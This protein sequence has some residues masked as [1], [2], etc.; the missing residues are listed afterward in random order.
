[1]RNDSFFVTGGALLADAGSY[2]QRA[3]DTELLAALR[4]GEFCYVLTTRQMGKT[5]LTVRAAAQLRDEGCAV[6]VLDLTAFGQNLD[7][8]QWYFSMLSDL[9]EKLKLED[10]MEAYWEANSQRAPLHRFFGAIR[11]VYLERK[12]KPLVIFV[13][14]IDA[15]RSLRQFKADEFFAGIRECYN[16][17]AEDPKFQKLTFCLLGV[18]TPSDLIS[19]QR[20]TPFNIGHG[21]ELADFSFEEATILAGGLSPHHETARA[22]LERVLEWTS[23][24]PYLTQR[25]C[26][27]LTKTGRHLP[28]Q[29]D[30]VCQQLFLGNEAR[31]GDENLQFVRDRLLRSE[32]D[33]AALLDTYARVRR[34]ELVAD[35][36]HSPIINELRLCGIVRV[37]DGRLQTRN[38]IY[39]KAFD[40]K[41]VRDHLPDAE[42]KRQR[43][44][45]FRGVRRVAGAA[46]GVSLLVGALAWQASRNARKAN[47]ASAKAQ[48][49]AEQITKAAAV[50]KNAAEIERKAAEIERQAALREKDA[51]AKELAAATREKETTERLRKANEDRLN[52]A[53]QT[54]AALRRLVDTQGKIQALLEAFTPLLGQKTGKLISESAENLVA[55]ISLETTNDPRIQFG[56]AGLRRVC[57]RLYLKLGNEDKALHQ[58]EEARRIVQAELIRQP[59]EGPEAWKPDPDATKRLLHDCHLLVGDIMLG[60]RVPGVAERKTE[61]EYEKAV[62]ALRE[63]WQ[64]AKVERAA[65]PEDAKWRATYFAD[66]ANLGDTARLFHRDDEARQHY[67]DAI[68]ELQA[69]RKVEP[70]PPDLDWLRASFHDR[71]GT[72]YMAQDDLE[73]AKS[74]FNQ[75]LNLREAGSG[76]GATEDLEQLSD[77]AQS[78]NKLG[79]LAFAAADYK[80]ALTYYERSLAMRQKLCEQNARLDWQRNLGFTLSNVAKSLW[81]TNQNLKALQRAGERWKLAEDLLNQ[82]PLDANLRYDYGNALFGYADILLNV[83]D[84]NLQD[85]QK[86]LELAR[87]AVGRTERRDPRCLA[88]LAQALRLNKSGAEA[89]AVAEE[90][91]KLLPPEDKRTQEDKEVAKE[92]EF[93]LRT[94]RN[95][96]G[97]SSPAAPAKSRK[98]KRS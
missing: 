76:E 78:Y 92:V 52:Q 21:I 53:E 46:V 22:L 12:R 40:L 11:E 27:E 17:R 77:I 34:G 42:A 47:E 55:G 69:M 50:E 74:E 16:R 71:L 9:A 57:G 4:A 29:V 10:E 8:E 33:Q 84:K 20:M 18:A 14:E 32:L 41:W 81:R 59:G 67:T 31:T 65:H 3:A 80:A 43:A 60:G 61:E 51:A 87:S 90:A 89:Y 98:S 1:M 64:L 70:A 66:W 23:G 97:S 85:W 7:V 68:K 35:D 93:E 88:L 24:H 37:A 95:S 6:V 91:S 39:S 36:H 96:R 19:D 26:A 94:S 5:S 86:A 2:V 44:A 72:L 75:G 56:Q 58:A 63:A 25:L 83:K 45:Y 62:A 54:E 79:N 49:L 13:D 48:Q 73:K 28:A 30:E 82:D 15:V 38:R